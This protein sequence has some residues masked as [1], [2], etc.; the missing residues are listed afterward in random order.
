M[1]FNDKM[2][3]LY[4]GRSRGIKGVLSSLLVKWSKMIKVVL[5]FG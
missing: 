2:H 4:R 1:F 5:K 3:A